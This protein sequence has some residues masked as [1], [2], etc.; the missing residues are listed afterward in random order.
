[1]KKILLTLLTYV[2]ICVC[3]QTHI[4]AQ[5]LEKQMIGKWKLANVV[6][7]SDYPKD[8]V[9]QMA[10]LKIEFDVL[11]NT[12]WDFQEEY[13][14]EILEKN[15]KGIYRFSGEKLYLELGE[16]ELKGTP[17]LLK[18]VITFTFA[19]GMSKVTF[20]FDKNLKKEKSKKKK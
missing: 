15:Q 8:A 20:T 5:S 14:Y 13:Q 16:R 2:C 11:K 9:A 12:I 10:K 3:A 6:V 17:T 4:Q 1:M 18:E 7:S 19:E